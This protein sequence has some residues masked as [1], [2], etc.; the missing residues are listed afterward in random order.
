MAEKIILTGCT[1][2]LGRAMTEGFIAAGATMAGIGRDKDALNELSKRYAPPHRFDRVDVSD[3]GAV[4]AYAEQLL[5]DWGTP[6]LLIN[7]AAIINRNAPLWE[8]PDDEIDQLLRINLKGVV[9]T[10]RYILPAMNA[11]GHGVVVNF[12]SGWGRST[13]PNVVPYCM[14]KWG[15]EGL[16][17]AASQEV[18]KGVA[19]VALNPGIIDTPMLRSCFGEGAAGHQDPESWAKAAV[20]MILGISTSDNGASLSV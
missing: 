13:S 3:D 11:A 4:Q 5:A 20:P 8:I 9:S 1:K 16:S 14:S 19:V 2:G 6:D 15:I 17:Q 12:S 7:N 10:M 18:A